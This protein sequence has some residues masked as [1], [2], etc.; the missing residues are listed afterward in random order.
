MLWKNAAKLAG[1]G[2]TIFGIAWAFATFQTTGS[3]KEVNAVIWDTTPFALSQNQ[4]FAAALDRLGHEPPRSYDYNGNEVF[5]SA[6]TTPKPIA[7][8]LIEYQ[9]EFVRQGLNEQAYV[10]VPGQEYRVNP[11]KYDKLGGDDTARMKNI[12]AMLSG[13]VAPM[14]MNDTYLTMGAALLDGKPK[15]AEEFTQQMRE[16][17]GKRVDEQLRRLEAVVDKCG[18]L[19]VPVEEIPLKMPSGE[20]VQQGVDDSTCGGDDDLQHGQKA[21][22]VAML[23][24]A[25]QANQEQ[26]KGCREFEELLAQDYEEWAGEFP[27]KLFK[28]FRS[29]EAFRPAGAR[30]TTVTATWTQDNFDVARSVPDEKVRKD[31]Y[32]LK[33][34]SVV[35][36]CPTCKHRFRFASNEG[37]EPLVANIYESQSVPEQLE[38]FYV[39][40]MAR[41]GWVRTE[42]NVVLQEVIKDIDA[43]HLD[44]TMVSFAKGEQHLNFLLQWLPEERKT[45][46]VSLQSD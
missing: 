4:K 12:E 33:P 44:G 35:P 22:R 26:F 6:R 19:K 9:E 27:R 8:V 42:A 1:A 43:S 14:Y 3:V 32:P 16:R 38:Q 23:G 24:R 10:T 18:G 7:D 11:A 2:A 17:A 45:K 41:K 13:Q 28:G 21:Y 31:P 5:F 46:V 20:M 29:I 40:E 30:E 15:S 34:D 25:I 37:N 36:A 39:E